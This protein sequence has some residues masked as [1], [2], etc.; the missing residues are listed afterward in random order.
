MI[1]LPL[2]AA[3]VPAA[4][5][6]PAESWPLFGTLADLV[7]AFLL[8]CSGFFGLVGSFGMVKLPDPMTRVHAPTKAATL[9]VGSVLIASM[10]YFWIFRGVFSWHE[11]MISIFL[12]ATA[13]ITGHFISKVQMHL[14]W[15]RDEIPQPKPGLD[16][17]T[18]GDSAHASLMDDLPELKSDRNAR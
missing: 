15:H 12:F 18:F 4:T 13:P 16:W 7:V 14:T 6:I 10:L 9:G 1:P 5:F 2:A 3:T 17:A 8:V 11:L